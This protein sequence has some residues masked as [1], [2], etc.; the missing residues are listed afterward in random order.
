MT[1]TP[2][3]IEALLRRVEVMED[4][5]QILELIAAY[6]PAVDSGSA[7]GTA[8]LWSED[9]EYDV[10]SGMLRGRE[11]LRAMVGSAPHQGFIT[12]GSAHLIGL[13]HVEVDGDRAVAIGHSQL[14][15][16]VPG[17]TAQFHVARITANRWELV[18][19]G[20]RWQVRR[21]VARLLDGRPEARELLGGV[22]TGSEGRD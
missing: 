18:K 20:G 6:G 8:A 21:R 5:W 2:G 7:D 16:K 12:N 1:Q 4:K 9:G 3:D 11:E 22:V 19:T 15:L 13:P 14:V 17:T 10:D